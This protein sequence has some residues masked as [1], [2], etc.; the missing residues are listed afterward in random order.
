MSA[1]TMSNAI[2]DRR[3]ILPAVEAMTARDFKVCQICGGPAMLHPRFEM[4]QIVSGEKQ[5]LCCSCLH[6]AA[7]PGKRVTRL[8]DQLWGCCVCGFVRAWGMFQPWDS[9]LKP[10]LGCERCDR[11]TRHRFVRVA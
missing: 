2:L 6:D 9:W 7:N 4:A 1:G 3:R 5:V 10:A 11:V 8:G